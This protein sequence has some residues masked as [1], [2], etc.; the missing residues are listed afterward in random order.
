[1]DADIYGPSL[2]TLIASES[3]GLHSYEDRPK[4]IIPIEYEGIK[5][6]SFG[7]AVKGKKAI[8]RGPMVSS[9]VTQLIN[10]TNWEDLDYL[11]VDFPPGTGDIQIT[12]GQEVKFDGAVIVT[13]P[14]R[15]SFIDVVK[16]KKIV[17]YQV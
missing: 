16:G 12:L 2:P 6:M 8:M 11:V 5:A 3:A 1:M 17:F 10:Q 7:F 9:V 15:L 4:E 14:Q 13:T